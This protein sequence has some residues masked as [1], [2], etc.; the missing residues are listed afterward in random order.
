MVE[1]EITRRVR[2]L[3]RERGAVNFLAFMLSLSIAVKCSTD[4]PARLVILG[5]KTSPKSQRRKQ[6]AR[7]SQEIL[8]RRGNSPR[9]YRNM[10][11]FLAADADRLIELEQ[12]VRSWLAWKSIDQE[13][14]QLNLNSAQARQV[15]KQV[16]HQDERIAALILET[17]SFLIVPAQEGTGPVTLTSSR[18]QGDNLLGRAVRKLRNDEQLITQWSGA[19]LRM[20]TRSLVVERCQPHRG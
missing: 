7:C 5:T 19:N 16:Q 6:G 17:Y 10:L 2:E 11:V 8:E 14:D 1:D 12:A 18:L 4:P 3:V 15:E 13:K 9:L 20:E